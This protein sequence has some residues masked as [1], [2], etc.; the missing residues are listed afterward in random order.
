MLYA[1][2]LEEAFSL[3][4]KAMRLFPYPPPYFLDHAGR[5]NYLT[6]RYEEAITEFQK[7]LERFPG[8][9]ACDPWAWLIASYMELGREEEAQAQV[10]KLLKK[11][12]N[13][14]LEVHTK[15]TKKAPFKDYAFLDSQIELLRKAG[16]PEKAFN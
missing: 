5:V 8:P 13:F 11:W 12:P 3:S 6:G 14:S 4:K 9:R 1:G 2:R 16:I 15:R 10:R 7:Y